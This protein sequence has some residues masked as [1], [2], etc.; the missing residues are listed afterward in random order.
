MSP[1]R[2]LAEPVGRLHEILGTP[3]LMIGLF[4]V[5]SFGFGL[6]VLAR[7]YDRL[8]QTGRATMHRVIEGWVRTAPV[9]D[10]GLTLVDYAALWRRCKAPE[11]AD[12]LE[13]VRQALMSLGDDF[14]RQADRLPLIQVVT[15]VLTPRGGAPLVS[16]RG[17]PGRPL[18]PL[19]L[20]DQISVLEAGPG[21]GLVLAVRYRTTPEV[22]RAALGLESSYRRL[23]LALLGLSGYSLLCLVYMVLHARTLR[24]RVAREAAREAT[25]DLADRTCH[26][27]GNVVFVLSNERSNLADHLDLVQRFVDEEPEILAAAARRAG[28][29]TAQAERFRA[30]L[31]REH[32][33]RGLDPE[34]ELRGGVAIAR[35][36]CRQ[37]AV[38]SEYIALTVRELDGYLKQ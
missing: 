33:E 13:R 29:E 32:A 22:E 36:V 38:C 6:L 5:L 16:W 26:E 37:I 9:D 24:D 20:E 17:Q 18:S 12:R 10:L 30:A 2:R 14:D 7:E 34:V 3:G 23:L 21:P 28:L 27:L 31:R 8:R 19:E 35:D 4:S 15:M 1:A 11:R 25:L